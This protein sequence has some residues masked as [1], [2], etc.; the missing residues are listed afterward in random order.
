MKPALPSGTSTLL[1]GKSTNYLAIFNIYGW[2]GE[3][4]SE[5]P[6]FSMV[7]P[8]SFPMVSSCRFSPASQWLC[9]LAR[10]PSRVPWWPSVAPSCRAWARPSKCW[11]RRWPWRGWPRRATG[12]VETTREFCNFDWDFKTYHFW[13]PPCMETSMFNE[14]CVNGKIIYKWDK[15]FES[16][17][18]SSEDIWIIC[19]LLYIKGICMGIPTENMIW[20]I[21]KWE[22]MGK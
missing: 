15:T 19:T 8:Y 17:I 18:K 20:I 5:N 7:F 6:Q 9:R 2:L 11:F 12:D 1:I 4:L 3:I 14:S 22:S 13:I 10:W 21:C 16:S